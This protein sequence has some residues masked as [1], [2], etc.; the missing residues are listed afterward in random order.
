MGELY[1][2]KAF[3][4]LNIFLSR[5]VFKEFSPASKIP[6]WV[7]F[8]MFQMFTEAPLLWLVGAKKFLNPAPVWTIAQFTSP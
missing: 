4:M 5:F 3:K 6:S 8:W 2:S 1:L 7:A